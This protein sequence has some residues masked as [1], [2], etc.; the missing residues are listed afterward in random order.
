MVPQY[1]DDYY[2]DDPVEARKTPNRSWMV[3][4]SLATILALIVIG[5]TV[6]GLVT[7]NTKNRIEFGQG[8]LLALPCDNAVSVKPQAIYGDNSDN[9]KKEFLFDSL[10]LSGISDEC[11]NKLFQFKFYTLSGS[12]PIIIGKKLISPGASPPSYSAD[13]VRFLMS[14]ATTVTSLTDIDQGLDWTL[15]REATSIGN[16]PNNPSFPTCSET[17]NYVQRLDLEFGELLADELADC[18]DKNVLMLFRGY[19][20]VPGTDGSEISVELST[21]SF[22]N[23]QI[24]IDGL[25]IMSINTTNSSASTSTASVKLRKGQSYSFDYWV[26]KGSGPANANLSWNLDSNGNVTSSNLIPALA[27]STAYKSMVK[28]SPTEGATDYS[29][30]LVSSEPNNRSIKIQFASPIE[31]SQIQFLTVETS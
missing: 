8:S 28:I 31:S 13:A 23:T 24:F 11:L 2:Y 18:L 26:L 9:G 4:L 19:L 21:T 6:G 7:V 20:T 29:V 27:Y 1:D 5:D 30:A 25:K 16:P 14:R 10:I 22:G 12:S 17:S 3:S 15:W